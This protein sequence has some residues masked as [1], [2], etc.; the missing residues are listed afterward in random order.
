MVNPM[1]LLTCPATRHRRSAFTLVE[2]LVVIAIIGVL[3]ALLLPAVQAVR[4]AAR[5]TRCAS[6]LSQ[7]GAAVHQYEMSHLVY[8]PGSLEPK[9]PILSQ[10]SG[11]HH[12]WIVSLLPY[13][14]ERPAA[15]QIDYSVG[16]YHD[17]NALIRRHTIALLLCP[18]DFEYGAV[19]NYAACHHDIEAPIDADNHGVFFLNSRVR[20]EDVTDGISHTLF[21]GERLAEANDLGWMSGTSATLRNTGMG[22]TP[23]AAMAT[24]PALIVGS[25]TSR[26]PGGANYAMGDGSVRF[27]GAL[28]PVLGHRSDGA[29]EQ[30]P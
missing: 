17:N 25:F 12:N 18:S 22:S 6:N 3:V 1:K 24:N 9:G 26:H 8:P 10:S 29:I 28:L 19:S 5:R 23:M 13:L 2:L 4:E 11:Y 7:M 21:F 14:E 20:F 27:L 30:M 16:V 15:E